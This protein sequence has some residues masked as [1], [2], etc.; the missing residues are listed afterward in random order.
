MRISDRALKIAVGN[1]P[2]ES[3]GQC[4]SLGRLYDILGRLGTPTSQLAVRQHA[5]LLILFALGN[6]FLSGGGDN[7][8]AWLLWSLRDFLRVPNYDWGGLALASTYTSL[9]SFSRCV[10]LKMSGYTYLL[11]V[12]FIAFFT[13]FAIPYFYMNR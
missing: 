6:T 13:F 8:H 11:E 4:F 3:T 5:R 7:V 10:S 2:Y 1:V 9:S 12:T